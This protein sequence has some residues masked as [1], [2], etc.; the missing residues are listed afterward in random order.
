MSKAKTYTLDERAIDIYLQKSTLFLFPLLGIK[1]E[2]SIKPANTY[3]AWQGEDD[4]NCGK[5]LCAFKET[6]IPEFA[7][8]E[9]SVLQESEFFID[10]I[11]L[12]DNKVIYRFD[13]KKYKE[14]IFQFM[15][16]KYSAFSEDTKTII[17]EYYSANK[18]TK[19]Y[20]LSYFYPERYF[21]KYAFLLN[22]EVALLKDVGELCNPYDP[23][24]ETLCLKKNPASRYGEMLV[25]H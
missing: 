3:L 4:I 16:G 12:E 18:Y 17:V 20:I 14:D 21:E 19:E 5:L 13:L 25:M 8:F 22:V 15:N 11:E 24:Q 2:I 23:L 1:R 7:H 9:K 6:N 10:F